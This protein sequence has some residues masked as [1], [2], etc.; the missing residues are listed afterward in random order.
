MN[1]VEDKG[2][3]INNITLGRWDTVLRQVGQFK[4]D[5]SKMLDL[6]EQIVFELIESNEISTA[7]MLMRKSHVLRLMNDEY[8][9]RYH[10]L[11]DYLSQAP[12]TQ[13][14]TSE[15]RRIQIAKRLETE[16]IVGPSSR[17]LTLLGQSLKWQQQ[18]G[19]LLPNTFYDIFKGKMAIQKA[20][21]DAFA[22][23]HYISIK[24]PGKKTYA[25]CAAFSR[26]GQYLV[27]GSVDG[28]IEIWNYM[29]GKLRK[30]LKYQANDSMMAMNKSVLCV[31]FSHDNEL[32]ATGSSDG[33][34]AIWKVQSGICQKK[35]N[36]AHSEGIASICFNSS[37]NQIMTGSYDQTVRI[38]GMKSGKMLKEFRGHT[39]FINSVLYSLDNTRVLSASSDGTVKIWDA[40]STSCLYTV[41]PQPTIEK[42]QLNPIGGLGNASVQSIIP[43]PKRPDQY[44]VCNKTNTIFVVSIRGQVTKTYSH[45]IK[46]GSDFIAAGTSPQGLYVY[47]LSEDSVLYCFQSTTG[48]LFGKVKISET[49]M[50]GMCSHPLSN[51]I[52]V[53]DDTGLVYLLKA[54]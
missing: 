2:E 16:I 18:Q 30:D 38:H 3:F 22:S 43:F 53:Y 24:F 11:E 49:E 26:N 10:V 28:F 14:Y 32:L 52:V 51:N 42:D 50:I 1:A 23:Q 5:E 20:E 40:K 17:L 4:F 44:L 15:E 39:S 34:I 48:S 29:T 46:T 13:K 36:A 7:K 12:S 41:A 31:Q 27:T 25:E 37:G 45:N 19:I 9:E 8:P 47:G 54:P 6:Y 35:I 33:K 21:D